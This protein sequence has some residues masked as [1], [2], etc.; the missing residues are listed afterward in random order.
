MAAR[1]VDMITPEKA[2]SFA[3]VNLGLTS[4]VREQ[5]K[6][7]KVYSDVNIAPMSLGGL[8]KGGVR[9]G[10]DGGV[11]R[12]CQQGGF[13]RSPAPTQRVKDSKGN[14]ILDNTPKSVAAM[15]EKTA[16]YMN[17]MLQNVVKQGT[18]TKARLDNMAVA[19][20][21]G[22]TSDDNDRWFVGYTPYYVSTVWFGFDEP[23]EIKLEKSTN[24]PL[25]LWKM[26]MSKVHEGLENKSFFAPE[27]LVKAS[28]CMDSGLAPTEYCRMDRRGS[29]VA[30]GLFYKEDVPSSRC[31]M[32]VQ[33]NMDTS[34]GQLA[35]PFCPEEFLKTIS[36][37][38]LNRRFS[39]SGVVVEDEQYTIRIYGEENSGSGYRA[40][41][42]SNK[43]GSPP[44]NTFC[45]AHTQAWTPPVTESPPPEENP[46]EPEQTE[47]PGRSDSVGA[48]TGGRTH[49][50]VY[51][52]AGRLRNYAAIRK[53]RDANQCP[54][55]QPAAEEGTFA[56]LINA[57]GFEIFE[58]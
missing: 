16:Y 19:G 18:G 31:T 2:F 56:Y 15:K 46:E 12:V 17:Y 3:S 8:T 32:H 1:V 27:G 6:G 29:R 52:A 51:T 42:P 57:L 50:Y 48:A 58:S 7:G 30:T 28:Y 11:L 5:E 35:T 44:L 38:D 43:S 40:V 24:P 26:V 34:T 33:V 37:L 13:T 14:V 4:L 53:Q 36:L 10:N 23:Q 20:K 54:F 9:G 47:D 21:T 25:A 39:V 22:T 49:R 45:T 41:T 55:A